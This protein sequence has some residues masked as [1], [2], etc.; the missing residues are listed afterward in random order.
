MLNILYI[1]TTTT[2]TGFPEATFSAKWRSGHG[3]PEA[4][5]LASAL[6]HRELDDQ[7][8]AKE[9]QDSQITRAFVRLRIQI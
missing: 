5:Q 4:D 2:S 6:L 9:A 7:D 8:W 3:S 1:C